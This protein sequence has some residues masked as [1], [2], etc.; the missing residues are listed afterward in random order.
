MGP[1]GTADVEF[2]VQ[3]LQL[4]HGHHHP[5][6]RTQSTLEALGAASELGLM[7][8][9][10][11][12]RLRSAYTFLSSLRN[13][14]FWLTGRPGDVL[15]AKFEDLEA[16]AIAMGYHGQPRQELEEDYLRLTRRARKVAERYIYE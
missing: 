3:I 5:A 14:L 7:P 2:A 1:G 4:R 10:D 9:S 6:L 13:R 12:H 16:L 11:A 8:Q 15:P